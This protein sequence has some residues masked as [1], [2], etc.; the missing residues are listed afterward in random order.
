MDQKIPFQET[1]TDNLNV[2]QKI[3]LDEKELREID[4]KEIKELK[5]KIKNIMKF[6]NHYLHLLDDSGFGYEEIVKDILN[7]FLRNIILDIKEGIKSTKIIFFN[8]KMEKIVESVCSERDNEKNPLF[9]LKDF[10]V[11]DSKYPKKFLSKKENTVYVNFKKNILYLM[12]WNEKGKNEEWNEYISIDDD[13]WFNTFGITLS[14]ANF[15][16]DSI[17][18]KESL[19]SIYENCE[20]INNEIIRCEARIDDSDE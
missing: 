19:E 9:K 10:I 7:T 17:D 20:E 13:E 15:L 1:K 3:K 11:T 4:E 2:P 18:R 5:T 12:E 6:A 8:E 16:I 14:M